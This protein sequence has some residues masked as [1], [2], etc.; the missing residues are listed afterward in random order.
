MGLT[1]LHLRPAFVL[2]QPQGRLRQGSLSGKPTG[3]IE[4]LGS[5]QVYYAN[6]LR[7][8][9]SSFEDVGPI[10]FSIASG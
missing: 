8:H 3:L 9:E 5:L 1:I 10:A 7:E 2:Q 6:S 4:N